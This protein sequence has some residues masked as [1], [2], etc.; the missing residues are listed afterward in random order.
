[1]H[2]ANTANP[3]RCLTRLHKLSIIRN[4]P[5][6]VQQLPS[7]SNHC[8]FLKETCGTLRYVGHNALQNTLKRLCASV[9]LIGYYNRSLQ[10]TAAT[11]LFEDGVDEQLIISRTGHKSC[12]GFR[13][14]KRQ[15]KQLR[16]VTSDVLNASKHNDQDS[17]AVVTNSTKS[18]TTSTFITRDKED[19]I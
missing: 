2:Y 17:N 18:P 16:K 3:N 7:V 15:T 19:K 12:D 11:R 5:K 9:G 10:A 4:T 1:M 13:S 8:K 14:C 6:I